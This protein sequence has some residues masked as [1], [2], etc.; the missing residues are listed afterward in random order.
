MA[1]ANAKNQMPDP[2]I[3]TA[4]YLHLDAGFLRI[5]GEDRL[6]FLQRQTTNN[7]DLLSQ[8]RSL[9]TVLTSPAGRILD[10]LWVIDEGETCGV[11]TLPGQG[12]QTLNFLQSRI[13]FMDKVI[14]DD[15]SQEYTQID[16][17]GPE[18]LNFLQGLSHHQTIEDN[19]IL[20]LNI[21]G[22]DII[23]LVQS[24]FTHRLLV[25]R[26][27]QE[28]VLQELEAEGA[29]PLSPESY[30]I[31]RIEAGFPAAR[32]ELTEDYTPLETGFDWTVS[33]NKGCYTGQEV[34][35]RQVNFDK[36]TRKLVGLQLS[37]SVELGD[38]LYPPDSQQPVGK[39]TSVGISPRFG[40]VALAIVKR[41]FHEAGNELV[42]GDKGEGILAKTT[43]L[44]FE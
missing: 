28:Q 39:V 21:S 14:V 20:Q 18:V 30:E 44:P 31:N 8:N 38:T 17:F 35:A 42:T 13:F 37:D 15:A 3:K 16:L 23:L 36:V 19:E 4:Y 29:E 9:V 10:V 40:P 27:S 12:Q 6:S 24:E 25:P 2:Q 41:P 7:M 43:D 22:V 32:H 33:D 26:D 11:I 34:I 1:D 5:S